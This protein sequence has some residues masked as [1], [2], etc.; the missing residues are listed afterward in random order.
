MKIAKKNGNFKGSEP[1]LDAKAMRLT[2]EIERATHDTSPEGPAYNDQ[3]RRISANL[4]TNQELCDKLLS[5]RL[6]PNAFAIMS[7]DEMA[8][9]ELQ[10]Q[11]AE[12]KA[13]AEKQSILISDDGPR[14]RRTHK[15]D[16]MVEDDSIAPDEDISAYRRRSMLDPNGNMAIRSR[17]NSVGDS[18]ELPQELDDY[19]SQDNI[20]AQAASSGPLSLNTTGSPP[21][22]KRQPTQ[23]GE[24]DINK[25]FSS[26]QS[27]TVP[28]HARKPSVQ[29]LA[30]D[31]PGE[32]AD[33]DR[34]L[35]DGN[36]SPPYSP[37]EFDSDPSIVWRG[38]MLMNSVASFQA[39]A[40]HIGGADL[41]TAI[42]PIA[43]A[44]L[45]PSKLS[46][47]G[48]IEKDKA[49]EYLCS[50]RW[51]DKTDVVVVALS[52]SGAAAEE[53]FT[54]LHNYFTEKK[55]YGVVGSK[56]FA[57]TRDTYLIPVSAGSGDIPEFMMN[58]DNNKLPG[59]RLEPMI[60][61]V[62][63]VRT[64]AVQSLD[65]P[66]GMPERQ[67]SMSGSQGPVMSPINQQ[68]S[69]QSQ[70][71]ASQLSQQAYPPPQQYPPQDHHSNHQPPV[72]YPSAADKRAQQAITQQ[73]GESTAHEILGD[74][75]YGCPTVKFLLPQ[76]Y[77]MQPSEWNVIKDILVK[78]EEARVDLPYLSKLL[79]QHSGPDKPL[80]S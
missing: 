23:A 28:H 68:G 7:G 61:I 70:S 34:M 60:L 78:H 12:M 51:S 6:T 67:M 56:S 57:N 48:R 76:A 74:E 73:K 18:S 15:G 2:L 25:V 72:P 63:V 58:L 54:R 80:Q 53:E 43:F 71:P 64:S 49:E 75:L 26:V 65:R 44:E 62:L 47:A 27:P 29:M 45:I 4:K 77:T 20:R 17:E 40:R 46:V 66:V 30:P 37:V 14:V 32:D 50:L 52:P 31:G 69:F 35:D 79:E 33:I 5:K 10:K 42:D 22:P 38:Q 39:V 19:Q 16:E 8:S 13:R 59:D 11:T 36:D 9:K 21:P 41:S 1:E 55:K 3:C 24:F